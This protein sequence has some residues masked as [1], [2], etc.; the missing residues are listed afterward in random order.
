MAKLCECGNAKCLYS[1]NAVLKVE[2][3]EAQE[4]ILLYAESESYDAKRGR[5]L[6]AELK[7]AREYARK[8]YRLYNEVQERIDEMAPYLAAH[9][10]FGYSF[11]EFTP[12]VEVGKPK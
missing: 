11:G 4:S 7:E 9:N 8:Y 2:L 1:R 10:V 5:D 3:A 6:I 12:N